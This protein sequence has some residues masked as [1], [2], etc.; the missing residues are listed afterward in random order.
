MM[1]RSLERPRLASL[2]LA[3]VLVAACGDDGGGG[4]RGELQ[5]DSADASRWRGA[6]QSTDPVSRARAIDLIPGAPGDD[7][8][9]TAEKLAV[10]DPDARVREQ[11]VLAYAALSG[12]DGERLLK[13]IALGDESEAVTSTA[14]AALAALR[15]ETHDAPRAWMKV[16]FPETYLPGET[17]TVRVQFGS[18]AP[19]PKATLQLR[20]PRGFT[21]GDAQHLRWRGS[22][23][24][25]VPQEITFELVATREQ[26]EAGA[27]VRLHVDY[28]EQLDDEELHEHVRVRGDVTGGRFEGS[29][30]SR[31][32][33][34]DGKEVPR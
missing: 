5:P 4:D 31:V 11:A 26:V 13:D 17:V 21:S 27:Q 34:V 18:A 20:P 16:E 1:R 8:L 30:P 9:A 19:A 23:E 14:R 6:I 29:A 2:A 24:A 28:E 10:H 25:G 12:A 32:R 22:I 3:S 15:A 33:G 7:G